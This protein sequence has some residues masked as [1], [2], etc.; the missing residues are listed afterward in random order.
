MANKDITKEQYIIANRGKFECLEVLYT[1]S[2]IKNFSALA[3]YLHMHFPID[4]LDA[5]K[6]VEF[7]KNNY[8]ELSHRF[9]WR[10]EDEH[11]R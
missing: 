8:V 10:K 6:I 3:T 5:Y 7:W 2:N 9:E 11:Q 1:K 4:I